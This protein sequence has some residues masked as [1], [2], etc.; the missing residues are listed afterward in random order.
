MTGWICPVCGKGLAPWVKECSCKDYEAMPY[1]PVVPDCTAPTEL[2]PE[3][4]K[5]P[6][7]RMRWWRDTFYGPGIVY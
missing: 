7:Q 4:Q 2:S 1:K 5:Y 6:P 3:Y